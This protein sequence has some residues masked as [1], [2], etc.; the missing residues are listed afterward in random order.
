MV[1]EVTGPSGETTSVLF[2]GYDA[3][4]QVPSIFCVCNH[5]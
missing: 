5:R 4:V 3:P 2:N 1:E